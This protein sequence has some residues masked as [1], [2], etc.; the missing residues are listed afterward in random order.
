MKSASPNVSMDNATTAVIDVVPQNDNHQVQ[1]P[2]PNSSS[3]SLTIAQGNFSTFLAPLNKDNFKHVTRDV[4]DKLRVVNQTLGMLDN[5]LDSQGFDAILNE[6]LQSITLKTGELLNADRSTIYLLDD[7]KDELWSIVA[8]DEK[9]NNLEL[10]FPSTAG[11]AGEV[12]TFK[13]VVNI[14]FDFY[15]DPR[16]ATA[17]KMDQKNGYRTFSMLAM[18]LLNEDTGELVAVVQL[19]NKLK[20]D[21]EPHG[22]LEDKIDT[23][24]FT[25][26]D[27]QV[28][29][30]F[31]PSIRL[32][33]ESSNPTKW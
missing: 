9:G 8:K 28:F 22:R 27:E 19:I 6:M 24:G 18:P 26:E 12:A 23:C 21:H 32:I 3:S 14:G 25:A 5:L 16:S 30:E 1:H 31:A 29:R 33:L 20:I 17:K 11:I 7:E 2:K 13:K 10:R 15:D 4:E